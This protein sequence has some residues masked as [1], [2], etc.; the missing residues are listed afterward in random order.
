ML[1]PDASERPAKHDQ[2]G[3]VTACPHRSHPANAMQVKSARDVEATIHP[4]NRRPVSTFASLY[5]F[6]LGRNSHSASRT[7]SPKSV[8]LRTR[9]AVH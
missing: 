8:A 6:P 3:Q 1:L 9:P 5:V 4:F 7:S 2:D